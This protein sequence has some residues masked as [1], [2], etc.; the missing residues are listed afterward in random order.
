MKKNGVCLQKPKE[1]T[2]PCKENSMKKITIELTQEQREALEDLISRGKQRAR[3]I[4][5][6]HVLLKIDSG[7]LGP[8]WSDQQVHEAFGVGEATIWRIRRRF[9]ETGLQDA[10]NRRP[11]PER[12]E[13]RKINGGQEAHLLALTCSQAP[14][15]HKRWTMRLLA[16]HMVA[17]GYSEQIS[18][19]TVW[20][21][22]KK[23][24]SSRG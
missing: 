9:V 12:P 14:T 4:M 20:V 11:Q 22:L 7:P 6:A 18:H 1:L 13:K 5:H 17:L 8:A 21:T 3:K 2:K 19:K 24:N 16:D 15:G 23:M 10:L